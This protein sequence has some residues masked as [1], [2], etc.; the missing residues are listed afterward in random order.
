MHRHRLARFLALPASC[1]LSSLMSVASASAQESP[2][3]PPPATPGTATN[4]PASPPEWW[5]VEGAQGDAGAAPA[6][7]APP[8]VRPVE[9]PANWAS[10]PEGTAPAASQSSSG[11]AGAT[12]KEGPAPMGGRETP[13]SGAASTTRTAASPNELRRDWEMTYLLGTTVGFGL[14]A[15]IG[16]DI[17]FQIREPA[18]SILAPAAIGVA[19]PTAMYLWDQQTP[20]R[21]GV[22]ASTATGTIVGSMAGILLSTTQYTAAANREAEWGGGAYS[23]LSVLAGIGGGIGGY[24]FGEYLKPD[25]RHL[26]FVA[27]GASIGALTGTMLGAGASGSSYGAPERG[28]A[29]GALLGYGTGVVATGMLSTKYMPSFRTQKWMW[30]GYGIGVGAS[31][32]VYLAYLGSEGDAKRGLIA[33]G[34]GGL[35]GMALGALFNGKDSDGSDISRTSI[36]QWSFGM[37][38]G[39]GMLQVSGGF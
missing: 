36:P 28:A 25:P 1:I 18:L 7:S 22:A 14:G 8:K 6:P 11:D 10:T 19:L 39:G 35:A 16:V 12:G 27:S 38:S 21:R 34:V 31:S 30:L 29:L 9:A 20:F 3:T 24:A 33:N 4:P 17:L 2:P 13:S 5:G 15:G 23:T 32:V 37:T 26:T